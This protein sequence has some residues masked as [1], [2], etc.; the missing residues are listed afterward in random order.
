MMQSF[1]TSGFLTWGT[2]LD[3]GPDGSGAT[4]FPEENTVMTVFEGRPLFGGHHMSSLEPRISTRSGWGRGG[5]R[6]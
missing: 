4:P 6:A 2:D 5:S 1:M 3:K